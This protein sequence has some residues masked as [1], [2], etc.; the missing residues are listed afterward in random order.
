MNAPLCKRSDYLSLKGNEFVILLTEIGSR[1]D[2]AHIAEKLLSKF[3]L[4]N[5]V[6]SQ[7]F[8]LTLS[9][10]ISVF[11]ENGSDADTL[12]KNSDTAMYTIKENGRNSYQFFE[13]PS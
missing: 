9:I 13:I 2:A 7:S 5:W 3:S 10:G 4:P 11:P 1:E 12:M 8:K 6:D